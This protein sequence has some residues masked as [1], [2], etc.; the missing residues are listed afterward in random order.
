MLTAR[1]IGSFGTIRMR[2]GLAIPLV[3]AA[4]LALAFSL[5]CGA[6]EPAAPPTPTP[7]D[8]EGIVNRA[9]GGVQ[10]GVTS[11]EV[12]A[13]IQQALAQQ[14]GV[15]SQDVANEI[16]KALAAQ[17]G[18]VTSADMAAAIA[19]A[20]EQQEPGIT[21]DDV[22]AEIAKALGAQQPGVT[23]DEVAMAIQSAL[24]ERPGGVTEAQVAA[25]IERA[26]AAQQAAMAEPTAAPDG[27]MMMEAQFGGFLELPTGTGR[28]TNTDPHK[29]PCCTTWWQPVSNRV[30]DLHPLTLEPRP[31]VAESWEWSDDLLTLTLSIRDDI[32]F[33]D[34][35]PVNGRKMTAE[36]VA[37]SLRRS[38]GLENPDNLDEVNWPR[39]SVLRSMA[40]AQAVDD[41]T[42]EVTLANVDGGFL[43]GLGDIRNMVVPKEL[44]DQ[45]GDLKDT[46][47]CTIGIGPFILD[48]FDETVKYDYV[49]NDNYWRRNDKGESLPYL[50]GLRYT[51]ISDKAAT[52]AGLRSG[53]LD[54]WASSQVMPRNVLDIQ[55]TNPEIKRHAYVGACC[56]N[57]GI[58]FDI[59]KAPFDDIRVRR[60][61]HLLI[62]RDTTSGTHFGGG[63]ES[64]G[65]DWNYGTPA[66]SLFVDY[67]L[68]QDEVRTLPGF[69]QPKTDDI[70]EA[71]MLLAAAGFPDGFKFQC[72]SAASGRGAV[73]GDAD[74][75]FL[76]QAQFIRDYQV[77]GVLPELE[78]EVKTFDNMHERNVNYLH[79]GVFWWSYTYEMDPG[80]QLQL[81]YGC[82]GGRNY[83]WPRDRDEDLCDDTWQS[84]WQAQQ[85]EL[86]P[87][88]RQELLHDLQRYTI[89]QVWKALVWD[90]KYSILYND[91]VH[92]VEEHLGP[93]VGIIPNYNLEFIWKN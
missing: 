69:R 31:Q 66:S 85:S 71:K 87:A 93:S 21:T 33:Q 50:E 38:R 23:S 56:G 83:V 6:D 70:E 15:T 17:P 62:D 86:D 57:I 63:P 26:L 51:A 59:T 34:R 52:I 54:M 1:N 91:R 67:A 3:L 4:A 88:K 18:G 78:I 14:P 24:A 72:D 74:G 68:P 89:D 37:Y 92:G 10:P 60:A 41:T 49:R 47:N 36:D 79:P 22:A 5:A 8:V 76:V 48:V 44:V 11:A 80:L 82:E 12:A 53:Q 77:S 61:I 84:K 16:A 39:S 58:Q 19:S 28:Q 75:C 9:L 40:D 81:T 90:P 27:M 45:C 25:A 42:V 46:P 64:Y 2:G 32:S 20:L 65:R 29:T 43:L 7:I 55:S 13:T 35:A 30:I 73:H